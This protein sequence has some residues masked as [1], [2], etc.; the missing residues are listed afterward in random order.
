MPGGHFITVTGG[1]GQI[2]DCFQRLWA[3]NRSY[4]IN[5]VLVGYAV[6]VV[7]GSKNTHLV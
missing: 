4:Y 1:G 5:I 3:V 6:H 7:L 2:A